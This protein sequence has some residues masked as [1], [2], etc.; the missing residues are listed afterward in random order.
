MTAVSAPGASCEIEPDPEP[1]PRLNE[2]LGTIAEFG[3]ASAE[4]VAWDL[5]LGPEEIRPAV[6]QALAEGLIEEAGVDI[7]TGEQLYRLVGGAQG[8]SGESRRRA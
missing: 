4:L 1:E 7:E 2:T 6:R 5:F 3:V 8:G